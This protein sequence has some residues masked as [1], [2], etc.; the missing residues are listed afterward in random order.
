MFASRTPDDGERLYLTLMSNSFGTGI[1]GGVLAHV[2]VQV[3]AGRARQLPIGLLI[4]AVPLSY[5]LY[6]VA[7]H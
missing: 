4:L 7:K 3:L 2:L 1:A 5:Y 6:T